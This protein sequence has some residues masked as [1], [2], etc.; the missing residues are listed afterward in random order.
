MQINQLTLALRPRNAYEAI[1]LGFVMARACWKPLYIIWFSL[2]LPFFALLQ[3][4]EIVNAWV[5]A[6]VIWWLKPLYDRMALFVYSR[7]VFGETPTVREAW[8]AVPGFFSTGLIS[9][10]TYRRFD[11]ARSFTLPVFQ[12]EGLRGQARRA[13]QNILNKNTRPKA[14][15][16]AIACVHLE[17]VLMLSLMAFLYLMTPHSAQGQIG[18][19]FFSN[20]AP[21]WFGLLTNAIYFIAIGIVEPFYV[22]AGFA[23]YLN[24]RTQLEGWDIE[25]AFHG[26]AE[27]AKSLDKSRAA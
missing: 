21:L 4:F 13:R 17:S 6:L 11:L 26:I 23:L 16:L 12:L 15:W 1:D 8:R 22:A 20:N 2:L 27:S 25:L 9:A 3:I 7:V 19:F 5:V 24:R 18:M 10:L 14:V